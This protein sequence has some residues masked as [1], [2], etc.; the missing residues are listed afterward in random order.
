MF[1]AIICGL[2][3]SLLASAQTI[4]GAGY[5]KPVPVPVAPGQILTFFVDGIGTSGIEA[6]LIQVLDTPVPVIDVRTI[7]TCLVLSAASTNGCTDIVAVTV[8]IPYELMPTCPQCLSAIAY[9]PSKLILRGNGRNA[10][11]DLSALTDQV[12]VLSTCDIVM[13]KDSGSPSGNGLPCPPVVT[14]GDGSLVSSTRPAKVG[15]TLTAWATGLGATNPAATTGKPSDKALPTAQ[16]IG[17]HYNYTVNALPTKPRPPVVS[18]PQ[19]TVLY[20]GLA[21]GYV[22][23]Y[24]LNFVVPEAPA[25]GIANCATVIPPPGT[26]SVNLPQSNLTVSFG[27]AY[28]FDGAGICFATR[29]PVD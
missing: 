17:I 16:P 9:F 8:Q 1:K 12:H 7:P 28:S 25:N 2:S 21:A 11:V 3:L 20:A 15:E 19:P 10:T 22:G 18:L 4:S 29:I 26:S 5:T 23:L 13:S 24:Q 14:H 6:T 27:G